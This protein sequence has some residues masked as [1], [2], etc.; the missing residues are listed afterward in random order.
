MLYIKRNTDISWCWCYCYI[1]NYTY[2]SM[3]YVHV[4]Y[5]IQTHVHQNTW[6][7]KQIWNRYV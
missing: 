2:T 7:Q 3:L 4:L 6:S 5:V 1:N